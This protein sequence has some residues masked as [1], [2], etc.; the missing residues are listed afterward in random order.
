ML[1]LYF[2]FYHLWLSL[3][4]FFRQ[5]DGDENENEEDERKILN[6]NDDSAD[7]LDESEKE[8]S[9]DFGKEYSK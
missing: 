9:G 2:L 1:H 5:N 3:I 7:E 8:E 6:R 4:H